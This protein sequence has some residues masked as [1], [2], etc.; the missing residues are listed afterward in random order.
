MNLD[1]I[2]KSDISEVRKGI[3]KCRELEE[4]IK[5]GIACGVDCQEIQDRCQSAKAFLTQVNEIYGPAFPA[6][7]S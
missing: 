2:T 3:V 5:R 6:K 1:N 7:S 4:M